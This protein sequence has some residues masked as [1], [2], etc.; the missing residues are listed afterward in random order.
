MKRCFLFGH[1]IV[2]SDISDRLIAAIERC[3]VERSVTE[4]VVGGYG[5]FD[6]LA[7]NAVAR[8]KSAYPT[9]RLFRLLPYH[10]AERTVETSDLFD[11]TVFPDGLERVPRRFAIIRANRYMIDRADCLITYVCYSAGNARQLLDYA[12]RKKNANGILIENLGEG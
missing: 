9:V 10:P 6:L 2:A 7:A 5:E 11:G 12:L 3:I 4:F 8:V 1:R